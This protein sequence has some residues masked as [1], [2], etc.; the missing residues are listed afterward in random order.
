MRMKYITQ[1]QANLKQYKTISTNR[2]T[3]RILD[4]SY[5]SVYKGKSMNFD[6]L[7]EYVVGDDRKDIDWKAS[8][9]SQK[10]LVKQYIAEKKHNIMMV[11]D[12]NRR[13]LAD[14]K[15]LE[16]KYEVALMSAG[17][18]A[19][20]VNQ[21]GDY[22]G[23]I[24]STEQSVKHFPFKTGLMNIENILEHYHKSV[25]IQN[26]SDMD[27]T[28]DY[29][30]RNFRRKMILVIVT[31]MEGIREISETTFKRLLIQHDI[32]LI[33]IS[34]ADMTGKKVYNMNEEKYLPEFFTSNKKLVELQEKKWKKLYKECIEKLKHFGIAMSSIDHRK[35]IDT[36]LIEL[37]HKHRYEK[38]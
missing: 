16:S 31:D 28:L 17:T 10:M 24:Y 36:K 1:I 22:V 21:N 9:R 15:E 35:D 33:R 3:S 8:A 7:R 37:L 2:A 32:L 30:I 19:C 34:D 18:L 20:L 5:H 26:K 13:M 14:T 12:T 38:R 25:T 23:A 11:M 4:G 29:I 27:K 6:E